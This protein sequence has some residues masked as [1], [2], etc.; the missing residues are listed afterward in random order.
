M[1]VARSLRIDVAKALLSH[2]VPLRGFLEQTAPAAGAATPPNSGGEYYGSSARHQRRYE[3]QI[4]AGPLIR[5]AMS[6]HWKPEAELNAATNTAS[7]V[8][9]IT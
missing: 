5:K 1:K 3:N 9:P 7:D 4:K 2:K 6:T 8:N